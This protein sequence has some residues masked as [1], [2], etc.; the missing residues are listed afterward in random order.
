MSK[1]S[2]NSKILFT[3]IWKVPLDYCEDEEF[4]SGDKNQADDTRNKN[5]RKFNWSPEQLEIIDS[6]GQENQWK[7]QYETIVEF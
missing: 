1:V 7:F 2:H 5:T 3:C 4:A 6:M